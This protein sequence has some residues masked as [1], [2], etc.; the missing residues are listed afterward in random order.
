MKINDVIQYLITGEVTDKVRMKPASSTP[1][2]F[3]LVLSSIGGKKKKLTKCD[4]RISN[5]L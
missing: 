2:F 5:V 1:S 4:G 3:I